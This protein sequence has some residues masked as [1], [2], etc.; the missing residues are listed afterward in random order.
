MYYFVFSYI[1]FTYLMSLKSLTKKHTYILNEY[2]KPE[3][4]WLINF[5]AHINERRSR[6]ATYVC[7]YRPVNKWSVTARCNSRLKAR[8]TEPR[9]NRAKREVTRGISGWVSEPLVRPPPVSLSPCLPSPRT[10]FI[11][12]AGMNS[13]MTNLTISFVENPQKYVF[14]GPF[15]RSFIFP[16][17]AQLLF[18][19]Y[20]E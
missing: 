15:V 20:I 16:R 12:R 1:N 3:R 2:P 14:C 11:S 7:R 6:V 9:E 4:C 10:S 18:E 17:C 19:T 5:I 13:L 8:P